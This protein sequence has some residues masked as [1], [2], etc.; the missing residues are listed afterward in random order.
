MVQTHGVLLLSS[1]QNLWIVLQRYANKMATWE[2]SPLQLKLEWGLYN[3][4]SEDLKCFHGTNDLRSAQHAHSSGMALF[5]PF[6]D[7]SQHTERL[8]SA[9]FS[10]V[11]QVLWCGISLAQ[12]HVW[13]RKDNKKLQ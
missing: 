6:G 9:T 1:R 12:D 5:A 3:L 7:L 13:T 4:K 8:R 2:L 11:R 10:Y